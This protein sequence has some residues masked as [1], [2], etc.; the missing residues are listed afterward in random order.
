MN[1]QESILNQIMAKNQL[2][3]WFNLNARAIID[4][5][6]KQLNKRE[7][8][9]LTRRFGLHGQRRETL[10]GIGK[11]HNL[12][13]E[14]IRQI[15]SSSINRIKKNPDLEEIISKLKQTISHLL[16]EHG[17][18]MS[19]EHLFKILANLSTDQEADRLTHD[20]Y[21]DFV[22]NKVL[23]KDIARISGN[24]FNNSFKLKYQTLDHLEEIA[25]ELISKIESSKKLLITK[26]LV[27]LIK[28]LPS[29]KTN[30]DKF[31]VPNNIDLSQVLSEHELTDR[32]IY[33]LLHAL[34]DIKQNK[35]GYWGHKTWR[36]V[37]PKTINDKI[38]LVLK[39][40]GQPMYYGDIAKKIA[41]LGFDHK[42]VN[43]ATTHNEL[44]LDDKY[45]LVGRGLY[46]LKEWGYKNGTVADV[47]VEVLKEAGKPLNKKDIADKVLEQR[48]VKQTTINLALMNKDRFEKVNNKYQIKK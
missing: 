15:E 24:H 14:R 39:N 43:T 11:L 16:E 13:R 19:R 27:D 47:V 2:E 23:D 34:V 42:K 46:G 41:E 21:L 36:E 38:Y 29:Y 22:I 31:V 1:K 20:N 45:I 26:E 12:T 25:E 17:G 8:D 32:S 7:Q 48:L 10:E 5:L 40:H 6:F 18:L 44:I 9:V 4:Q 3:D 30:E 28:Q 35:F 37:S 33:A